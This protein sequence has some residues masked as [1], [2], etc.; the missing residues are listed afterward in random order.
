M[1][2][3]RLAVWIVGAAVFGA[4]LAS[5]A[6]VTRQARLARAAPPA[7]EA[8]QLDALA[9]EVQAQAGHLRD[10]LANAPAPRPAGRNPF[11]FA[12]RPARSG[13][14]HEAP[15]THAATSPLPMAS[16]PSEPSLELIGI[17]ESPGA[18]GAVRTAMITDAQQDLIMVIAGQRILGRY[19]VVSIG[20]DAVD[21]KDVDSGRT[22]RLILR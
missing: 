3:S 22:R 18:S 20:E 8:V 4:W 10:R 11:S 12:S 6:G 16:T 5:A 13:A 15:E 17:A 1:S 19:D 14:R 7:P 21:L 9:A 2:A